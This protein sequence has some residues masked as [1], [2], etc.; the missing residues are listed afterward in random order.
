M[1]FTYFAFRPPYP[2]DRRRDEMDMMITTVASDE[3]PLKRTTDPSKKTN[4]KALLK[5]L[6]QK[7]SL[8]ML[9]CSRN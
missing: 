4:N 9:F 7:G 2:F 1:I 8:A 3:S 6:K 5:T